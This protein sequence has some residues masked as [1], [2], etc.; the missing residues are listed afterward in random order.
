M[1]F[2]IS[3][4]T[5]FKLFYLSEYLSKLKRFQSVFRPIKLKVDIYKLGKEEGLNDYIKHM[6]NNRE[7][8]DIPKRPFSKLCTPN[9]LES[10]DVVANIFHISKS[11]YHEREV[12]TIFES[13]Q[14]TVGECLPN[15]KFR[16]GEKSHLHHQNYYGY[17][18]CRIL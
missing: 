4:K 9:T 6:I 8:I 5:L 1:T 18:H 12:N 7:T 10:V 14:E 3:G 17:N 2:F 15:W 13:W 11:K 16:R